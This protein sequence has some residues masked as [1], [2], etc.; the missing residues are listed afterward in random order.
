VGPAHEDRS[1]LDSVLDP[2]RSRGLK[3]MLW[4]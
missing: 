4:C 1:A 2:E 3:W